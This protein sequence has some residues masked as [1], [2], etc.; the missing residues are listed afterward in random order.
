MSRTAAGLASLCLRAGSARRVL[1]VAHDR[2]GLR[3]AFPTAVRPPTRVARARCPAAGAARRTRR[4]RA[5]GRDCVREE[6]GLSALVGRLRSEADALLEHGAGIGSRGHHIRGCRS[7]RRVSARF[8]TRR[9]VLWVAGRVVCPQPPGRAPS[10]GRAPRP[11]ADGGGRAARTRPRGRRRH[12]GQRARA[13]VRRGRAPRR[14]RRR[15]ARRSRCSGAVPTWSIQPSTAAL[16]QRI[17][18]TRR[19]RLRTG[20]RLAAAAGALSSAEPHHQRARTGRRGGRGVGQER[21]A[22]SRRPA[23]SSRGAT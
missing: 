2:P 6:Q 11:P 12:S 15:R 23:R 8:P 16:D 5:P 22:R 10:S 19:D 13:R 4:T 9:S 21:L 3:R 1:E 17:R 7:S 14:P 18:D 20:S